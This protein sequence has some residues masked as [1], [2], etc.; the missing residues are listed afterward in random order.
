MKKDG[1]KGYGDVTVSFR[2]I[3]QALVTVTKKL[4]LSI[5]Q[6]AQPAVTLGDIPAPRSG[7]TEIPTPCG[8]VTTF[9]C[10]QD[11]L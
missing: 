7:A 3:R 6:W 8:S 1:E 9:C 2:P 4:V 5:R 10:R 11:G